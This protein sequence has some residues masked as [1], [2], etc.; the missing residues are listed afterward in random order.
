MARIGPVIPNLVVAAM[1][2]LLPGT[3]LA[4]DKQQ[5]QERFKKGV[6]LYKDGD[7]E[8]A[9][10]EF[11]A[12]YRFVP[13]FLVRYNIGIT[14]YNL[15]RYAEAHEELE[16]YLE[17]GGKEIP[18]ERVEEVKQ[19]LEK[20][21]TLIG[22]LIIECSVED[23]ELFIDGEPREEWVNFLDVGEHKIEVRASGYKSFYEKV[24]LPG[25]MTIS[26]DIQLEPVETTASPTE[27][28]SSEE[29]VPEEAS[30]EEEAT[31]H[32]EETTPLAPEEPRRHKP[33]PAGA[34]WSMLGI[35]VAV[36][37]GAAVLGGLVIR[38]DADYRDLGSGE[39]WRDVQQEGRTLAIAADVMLGVTGSFALV[40]LVLA[41]FT[42]FGEGK[43]EKVALSI[44]PAADSLLIDLGG[45][46]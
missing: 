10:V 2:I 7:Y 11:K 43:E 39:D 23:A 16:A 4:D 27:V 9:L 29:T 31:T 20:L 21:Q 13:H 35:T 19:I 28:G 22:E 18:T 8:G 12:A 42:D 17:E 3:S 15:H 5:A 40:T 34:F 6:E 46:F 25:G 36:G 1:L 26:V 32:E 37:V 41:F 30:A 38:K 33:V 45:T 44:S 14:L 24:D